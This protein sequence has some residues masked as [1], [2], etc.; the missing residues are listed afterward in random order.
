MLSNRTMPPCVVI[1][2]LVYDDVRVASR[3][4]CDAF[5]FTVRWIAGGHRAQ[6]GYGSHG[7]VVLTEARAG[8]RSDE[9]I[10][11]RPPRADEVSHAVLVRVEDVDAHHARAVEH[12]ARVVHAPADFP[13]GERQYAALDFAGHRWTFTQSIADVS[14]ED[15]GGATVDLG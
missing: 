15:W 1:P 9:E 3:W 2:E 8:W 5:G 13:Y 7:A 4:L 14:P 12:G 11:L 10:M 6:L